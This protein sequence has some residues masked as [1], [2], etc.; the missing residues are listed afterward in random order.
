MIL[1]RKTLQQSSIFLKQNRG[2]AHLTTDEMKEM[3]Q[4]SNSITFMSKLSRYFANIG[5]TNAY[6]H[7]IRENLKSI[8]TLPICTG[9]SCKIRLATTLT[10]LQ[11][12]QGGST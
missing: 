3:A 12:N 10:I 5:G 8:V 7:N 1:R 6:W 11:V 2:K 9:V 4:N